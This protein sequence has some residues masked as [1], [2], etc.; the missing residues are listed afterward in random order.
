MMRITATQF[1]AVADAT[2]RRFEDEMVAHAAAFSPRLAG[3]LGPQGLRSAVAAAIARARGFRLTCRGPLR[4]CV[5]LSLL[6]GSGFAD[7]PQYPELGA[8]LRLPDGEMQ[9]ADRLYRL[10]VDYQSAVSGPR[11]RNL[12]RALEAMLEFCRTP[13]HLEDRSLRMDMIA[14]HG[15][16]YPEKSAYLGEA[17]LAALVDRAEQEAAI[18]GFTAP[19]ARALMACLMFGFGH[20][21]AADPL[22]PWIGA[23][24]ADERIVSV[25]AR[26][27]R[28]ERKAVTWLER[29]VEGNSALE[30]RA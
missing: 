17:R 2:R 24:L 21:C 18:H 26:A 19:R 9:R 25:E 23:T 10:I 15:R 3:V 30:A 6:C 13:P 12:H 20:E 5:E 22:Y 8:T 1:G 14:A 7:D 27:S 16:I 4:T 11:A 28:L 29:V